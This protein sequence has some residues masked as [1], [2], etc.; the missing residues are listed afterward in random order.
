MTKYRNIAQPYRRVLSLPDAPNEGE[1]EDEYIP[2]TFPEADRL[3][4]RMRHLSLTIEKFWTRWRM[5]YLLQLWNSHRGS[6]RHGR[7]GRTQAQVG[8]VVVIEDDKMP[9]G[10]WKLDTVVRLLSGR[11]QE[12]RAASVK[13]HSKDGKSIILSRPLQR[14]Y[15]LEVQDDNSVEPSRN[16]NPGSENLKE[17]FTKTTPA[18]KCPDGSEEQNARPKRAAAAQARE[19]MSS[20]ALDLNG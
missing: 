9:R 18:R 15:P 10:F 3:A 14:L 20:W 17:S 16:F 8:D 7:I 4:R 19:R 1:E 5:E 12:V 2:N 13:T 11:D 6:R